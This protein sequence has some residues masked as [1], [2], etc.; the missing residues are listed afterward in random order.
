MVATTTAA[1]TL[2][3]ETTSMFRATKDLMLPT[4]ITGSLPRPSWYTEN[5]GTSQLP[6]RDGEQ[7]LPRAVRRRGVGLSA[8]AGT[9]PASTSSPTATAHFDNDVGGQSW[10][11][12]PP[13]HMGGFDRGNPQPTPAGQR[14]PRVS[15]RPHPARLSGIARD[16]G[17]H[18]PG[19]PRRPAIRRDVEGGAALHQ[20]A[21]EVRHASGRSWSP[22]R[23]RTRTTRAS[24]DRIMAIT[25]ALQRGTARARRRRL[26]GDPDRGAADPPARGAQDRRRGDQPGVHASR[27]STAR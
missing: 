3:R 1:N 26:P 21:G 19:R 27:C 10:T 20:E 23:C 15:A 12:Y 24:R 22:S 25:D 9:S 16:A 7:P 8:R 13:R 2:I 11:N 17:D 14:R 18:R 4:T 5:L 6:R